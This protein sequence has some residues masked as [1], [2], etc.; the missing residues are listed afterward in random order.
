MNTILG[1]KLG[2]TQIYDAQSRAVPV[3]VIKA[4]PCHV[5]QV[6]QP[7]ADGYSA[8]Q[9]AFG[10]IRAKQVNKP[11]QGHYAKA[12]VEPA[13]YLVEVRVDDP[14]A[15]QVGQKIV[16]SDVLEEGKL[17]DVTGLS[18]GKGFQ[19]VMRRH[20]FSGQG[21][22]HGNHKKHRAPG[23]IGACATPSRVFKGMR[24]AGRMGGDQVTTLNLLIVGVDTER[25]L[26]MLRGAVP[27]ANGSMVLIREAVKG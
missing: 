17:A 24:M 4:G 25:N 1:E 23:S 22:A 10:D 9:I 13:R 3:T 21:A 27:G 20:N 26:L 7:D 14:S 5:V 12:G 18:K 6:K 19:G 11:I 8:I 15:Y 16:V 2:M